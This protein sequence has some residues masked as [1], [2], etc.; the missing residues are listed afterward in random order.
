MIGKDLSFPVLQTNLFGRG[1]PSY[2]LEVLG[3]VGAPCSI[4][5]KLCTKAAC[6]YNF[7]PTF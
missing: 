4:W 1:L 6:W 7:A 2:L 5:F 3:H